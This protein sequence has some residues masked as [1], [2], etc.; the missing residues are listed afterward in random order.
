M[1]SLLYHLILLLASAAGINGTSQKE[2]GNT[3]IQIANHHRINPSPTSLTSSE[4]LKD[5]DVEHPYTKE[6]FCS[7]FQIHP[8]NCSCDVTPFVC[9]A[10]MLEAIIERKNDTTLF[11]RAHGFSITYATVAVLSSAFG[12]VGNIAVLLLAYRHRTNISP[13]KLHI[14]QLAFVNL[15]FSCVQVINVMPLYWSNVW[16][17]TSMMCKLT[18][19]VLEMGSL[20]SSGFFLLITIERYLLIVQTFRVRSFQHR[21]KHTAVVCNLILVAFTVIPYIHGAEIEVESGRCTNFIGGSKWVASTYAWFTFLVFSVLPTVFTTALAVRLKMYF[22]QEK[23]TLLMVKRDNMNKNIMGNMLLI[24]SLFIICTLPSRLVTISMDMV[25]FR[26][27]RLI[28]VFQFISYIL[29][30]FQGTLNPILYS[31]L[32]KQWRRNL[33]QVVR[34]VFQKNTIT[35]SIY[36]ENEENLL[37]ENEK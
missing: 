24:L 36:N 20:L 16:I 2:T 12:V 34:S 32:A 11:L 4:L 6:I 22:N 35:L 28:L 37:P 31:M 9:Q 3:T 10:N 8:S 17:Y 33:T 30:S 21:Y 18:R 29:Y 14:A 27:H 19:G 5:E 7:R 23:D 25:D 26:S 13:C 1:C 15:V